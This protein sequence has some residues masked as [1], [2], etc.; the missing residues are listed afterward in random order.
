MKNWVD[1]AGETEIAVRLV[2]DV[3]WPSES[4]VEL[5][6]V[7][8]LCMRAMMSSPACDST[9]PFRSMSDGHKEETCPSGS[10]AEGPN[11]LAVVR[12]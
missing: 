9:G 10:R 7:Y 11:K 12:G 3:A 2:N 8:T 6:C 4:R 5:C 1:E